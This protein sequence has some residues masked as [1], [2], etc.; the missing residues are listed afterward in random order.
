MST[1]VADRGIRTFEHGKVAIEIPDE[2]TILEDGQEPEPYQ[3]CW[4]FLSQKD[5]DK[6]VVW[7]SGSI[8]EINAAKSMFQKLVAEGMTPY[9]VGTGGSASPTVMDEFDPT[10]EEVIF[11][12]TK[13]IAAG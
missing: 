7:N 4:R 1:A 11:M 10:A 9:R 3:V 8:P 5:G 6:R 2:L 12:P 13:M